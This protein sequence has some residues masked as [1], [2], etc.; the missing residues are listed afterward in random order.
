MFWH[1]DGPCFKDAICKWV[2]YPLLIGKGY[3]RIENSVH[4]V[5]DKGYDRIDNIVF[6]K[7]VGEVHSFL[8]LGARGVIHMREVEL[9]AWGHQ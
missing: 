2:W 1:C 4:K 7:K 9:F 6:I 5:I 8:G 3:D